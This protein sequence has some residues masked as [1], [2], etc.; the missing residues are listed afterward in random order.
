MESYELTIR[1][2]KTGAQ[3]GLGAIFDCEIE[4]P[5][6]ELAK[7]LSAYNRECD[8]LLVSSIMSKAGYAF[9]EHI[10]EQLQLKLLNR[11]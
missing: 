4:T 8:E 6:K 11:H 2:T 1:L 3:P 5:D 7:K 9:K 10:R